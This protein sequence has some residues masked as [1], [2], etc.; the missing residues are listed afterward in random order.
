MKKVTFSWRL[1]ST[2]LLLLIVIACSVSYNNDEESSSVEQTLQAVYM[3]DTAEALAAEMPQAPPEGEVETAV[4]A[5]FV[6]PEHQTVPGNPGSAGQTKNEIDTSNTADDKY[7]LGDS[8]RL[9]NFERPFTES[10]MDYHPETDMTKLSLSKGSDFYYFTIEVFSGSEDGGFPSASYGI[11]FDT[12][13]DGRGDVLL[14]AEGLDSSDWTIENVSVLRDSNDDVGGSRP[15]LPDDRNGDGFDEVL[16][17]NEKM[18]DPDAAW[19]LKE[20]S[21]K[22]QLA[23]K[24]TLVGASRFMWRAWADA[25]TADPGQF[26]YNDAFSESQAGS[27]VKN[28]EFYPVGQLNLVDSTCWINYGYELNYNLLG[29]CDTIPP[30]AEPAPVVPEEPPEEPPCICKGPCKFYSNEFCCNYCGCIWM[31]LGWFSAC[32]SSE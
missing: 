8:F 32:I 21:D 13:L 30:T 23:I 12:D 31:D 16:F 11:E 29:G 19:Q 27:P 4:E 25:G 18:D 17:S 10:D 9:N 28:S 1:V 14:W 24:T 20:A 5:A 7:A 22:I 2:A 6:E 3:Q 26:D 15:V